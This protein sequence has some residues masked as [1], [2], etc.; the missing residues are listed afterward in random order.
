MEIFLKFLYSFFSSHNREIHSGRIENSIHIQ[1]WI[2]TLWISLF[3]SN[4]IISQV[5]LDRQYPGFEEKMR[6]KINAY[7]DFLKK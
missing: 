6:H 1:F 2:F 3:R 4:N 7:S 5:F